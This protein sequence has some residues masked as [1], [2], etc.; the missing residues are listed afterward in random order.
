MTNDELFD[1]IDKFK[2]NPRMGHEDGLLEFAKEVAKQAAQKER[3]A[4]IKVC[5]D[6][7]D[8][9]P[10]LIENVFFRGARVVK[11]NIEERNK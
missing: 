10:A 3:D 2:F 9:E 6:I 5:Q 8:W 7:I 1:I 11:Q 4:C